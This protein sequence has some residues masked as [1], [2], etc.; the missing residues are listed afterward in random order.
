M[1][2]VMK[3]CLLLLLFTVIS[4]TIVSA[5][6][7]I[8]VAAIVWPVFLVLLIPIIFLEVIVIAQNLKQKW[9]LIFW[10]VALAN[11]VTT[12]IGYPVSWIFLLLYELLMFEG[13]DFL[14]KSFI[15]FAIPSLLMP[16]VMPAWMLPD[17]GFLGEVIIFCAVIIGLVVSF[18][19]SFFVECWIVKKCLKNRKV[20]PFLLKKAIWRANI[21]SYGVLLIGILIYFIVMSYLL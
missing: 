11:V 19:L 13:Y 18:F 7:G 17:G 20:S 5:N 4:S 14:S 10:P 12:I 21:F 8:P 1:K 16:F 2:K 3:F 9:K 15:D 6:V